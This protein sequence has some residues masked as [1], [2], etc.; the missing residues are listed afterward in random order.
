MK[1]IFERI[2]LNVSCGN[3]MEKFLDQ[4]EKYP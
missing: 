4:N 3:F 2:L 1:G